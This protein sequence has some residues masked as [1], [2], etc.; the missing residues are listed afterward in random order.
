MSFLLEREHRDLFVYQI[1][2][3]HF[4]SFQVTTGIKGA[5]LNSGIMD[6]LTAESGTGLKEKGRV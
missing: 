5:F 3:S 4:K 1:C 6:R 2:H